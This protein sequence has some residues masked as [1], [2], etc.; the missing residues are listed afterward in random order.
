MD[1]VRLPPP[2]L[3][4]VTK[5]PHSNFQRPKFNYLNSKLK[6]TS[7]CH[8]LRV[9]RMQAGDDEDYDLKQVRD[10]AAAKRRW[11]TM[12]REGRV[13][14]L[15]PREAGYAIQLS[16]KT[17]LDVRP[18]VE[19]NKAWIKGS[20]WIPIFEADETS[21]LGNLS[22]KVTSF[23][24]GGW[25]SGTPTLSFNNQFISNVEEKF[26]KDTDL[27]VS[28][29]RGLRSL[30]ACEMLYNAGYKN[31]FWVQGGLEAAEEEDLVAEGPQPLKLAGIGGVSEFLGW[32]DQQRVV[33]AKEG[34]G[35]RLLFSARLFGVVI[36]ADALFLGAQQLS[37][38]V[39]DIRP[40]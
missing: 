19:R 32:T 34:W 16:N 11:D 38:Y 18:S 17:L 14:V 29:Q 36:A 20:D 40:H 25:W 31:L 28:C 7:T 10:M 33:A 37:H 6:S 39:Q 2:C 23:M 1:S 4:C 21:D 15:T 27:I 8:R 3:S 26:P 22:R 24:M 12:I 35:Y 9:T 5:F 30:A 13:K